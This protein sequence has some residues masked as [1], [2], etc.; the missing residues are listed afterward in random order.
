M[1]N[2]K[3]GANKALYRAL[4]SM[5]IPAIARSMLV[6]A[7]NPENEE[8]KLICH[9][10]SSLAKHGK[11]ILMRI[12]PEQGGIVFDG[13]SDLK[14]DDVLSPDKD[15]RNKPSIKRNE[16]SDK[17]LEF[18]F[19][20]HDGA[21]ELTEIKK[22]QEENGWSKNTLYRAKEDLQLKSI[23]T[24]FGAGKKTLWL[25]PNKDS[26]EFEKSQNAPEQIVGNK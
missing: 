16:V 1:H 24:G 10:K 6:M 14:A 20:E 19:F 22:L 7:K 23:V 26:E 17:L 15:G 11:S 18:L 12:E 21:A 13:F 4:G 9:E 2:S 5:D 8:Q 25:M 3:M